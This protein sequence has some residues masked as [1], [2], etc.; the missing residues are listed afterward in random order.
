M[1]WSGMVKTLEKAIVEVGQL[2]DADQ[3]EI[4]RKVLT[5]IEKLQRLRADIDR[6]IQSLDAGQGK[7]LDV[8]KL[9]ARKNRKNA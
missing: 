2:S 3:E 9:I 8:E 4:G 7:E 5:H 6:G 1:L